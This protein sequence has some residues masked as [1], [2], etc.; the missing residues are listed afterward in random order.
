[1]MFSVHGIVYNEFMN[2][3]TSELYLCLNRFSI[4]LLGE[5]IDLSRY[6]Y[7]TVTRLSGKGISMVSM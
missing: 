7:S 4:I 5:I 2:R 3:N 1:M 6:L